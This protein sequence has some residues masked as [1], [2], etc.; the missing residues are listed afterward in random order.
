MRSYVMGRFLQAIPVMFGVLVV[1]FALT[2]LTPGDPAEIMAGLEASPEAIES[3]RIELGL[4]QPIVTQFGRY[5]R[6][7]VHGDLGRS[8][9]LGRD[10]SE[11]IGEALPNTVWLALVALTFTVL[12]AVPAGVLSAVHKDT[13]LD[14]AARAT[15]L[16]GVSTPPFFAGLLSILLF[17]HYVRWFP[18]FGSGTWKHLILPG[19]TLGLFSAGLVMRLT[20]SEMLDVLNQDY[21]RTARAKG[22]PDRSTHYVHALRNAAISVTTIMGLQLGGLLAGTVLTE[23]VFSY[24]GV[25]RLLARSIFERDYPVVQGLILLIAMVYVVVN[26]LVDVMYSLIDPRIRVQ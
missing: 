23:T 5:L 17:S 15:A 21:I 1:T 4:D 22:L 19:V 8:F 18:S 3:I 24:P 25:G 6:G 14:V 11:L 13:W 9:Y 7:I 20:R 26:L 16:L 10:V 12:I 2:R